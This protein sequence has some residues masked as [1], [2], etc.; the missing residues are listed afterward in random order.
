MDISVVIHCANSTA[1]F[2]TI[3]LLCNLNLPL[4]ALQ[5]WQQKGN[6]SSGKRTKDS[7]VG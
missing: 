4:Q 3:S 6:S 5:L 2:V 1:V 7:V